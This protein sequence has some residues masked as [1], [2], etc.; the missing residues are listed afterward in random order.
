MSIDP[1]VLPKDT[2]A[3]V[4]EIDRLTLAVDELDTGKVWT[5]RITE[6]EEARHQ[7]QNRLYQLAIGQIAKQGFEDG[8]A[9]VIAGKS[10][11]HL[12]LPMKAPMAAELDDAAMREQHEFE[13]ALCDGIAQMKFTDD[14]DLWRAY[15]RA[16][17]SKTLRVKAF[18]RYL[19]RFLD[20]WARKGV[21]FRFQPSERARAIA[22]DMPKEKA[23]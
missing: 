11:F 15:D 4:R 20:V 5:I 7:L 14:D 3:R 19:D 21:A 6:G 16:I 18:A 9:A 17:R 1:F 2:K 12:L 10:K 23:A 13:V 22:G 8:D